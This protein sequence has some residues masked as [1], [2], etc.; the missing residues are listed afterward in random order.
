MKTKVSNFLMSIIAILIFSSCDDGCPDWDYTY[1]QAVVVYEPVP[2]N[3]INAYK[4][5]VKLTDCGC[6]SQYSVYSNVFVQKRD[7]VFVNSGRIEG[8]Y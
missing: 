4:V 8:T 5:I 6:D 7:T 3:S 2:L 1:N